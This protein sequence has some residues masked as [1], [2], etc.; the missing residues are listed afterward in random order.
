MIAIHQIELT[1]INMRK[2]ERKSDHEI[3]TGNRVDALLPSINA[4]MKAGGN[5][6]NM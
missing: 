5:D 3:Y 4:M 6:N 1:P 2:N